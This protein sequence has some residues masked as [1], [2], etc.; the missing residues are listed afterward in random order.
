MPAVLRALQILQR[1]V[2]AFFSHDISF[3]RNGKRVALVLENRA[4]Q[5][6]A[7]RNKPADLRAQREHEELALILRQLSALLSEQ[8][9]T[10]R[11]CRHLVF[12]EHALDKKG[13][14]ALHK[15]PLDVLQ[16]ALEQLE[17]LV[18]NWAPEGLANLRSK[19]AV[20]VI[21]REHMDPNAEADAYNTAMPLETPEPVEV[22]PLPS[23]SEDTGAEDRALAAAYAAL[24][25]TG[26]AQAPGQAVAV[27]MQGELASPSAKAVARAAR[28]VPGALPEIKLRELER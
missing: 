26:R 21:D 9:E 17:A 5:P 18:T 12:V 11:R 20:T 13:L 25:S 6:G 23:A 2:Q 14:R 24:E 27:E 8:P 4:E 10:R 7:P 15:L 28:R 3:K 16:P 1:A 22:P 19:L